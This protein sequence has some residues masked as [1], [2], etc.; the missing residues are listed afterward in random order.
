MEANFQQ[1]PDL[2]C[3]HDLI[4]SQGDS[5]TILWCD[6]RLLT[7]YARNGSTPV[8]S[9]LEILAALRNEGVLSKEEYFSKLHELRKSNVRYLPFTA[10]EILFELSAAPIV[11][12]HVQETAELGTLRMSL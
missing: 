12:D 1:Q 5:S 3:L 2:G 8:V 7:S 4:S 6:D 11:S 9:V 10:E